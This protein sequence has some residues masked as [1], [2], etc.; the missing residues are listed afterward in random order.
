MNRH[1]L[2]A[3]WLY[4]SQDPRQ[5]LL[6]HIGTAAFQTFTLGWNAQFLGVILPPPGVFFFVE[7]WHRIVQIVAL[8]RLIKN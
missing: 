2:H 7:K 5:F 4:R 6:A 1:Q 3:K 8:H